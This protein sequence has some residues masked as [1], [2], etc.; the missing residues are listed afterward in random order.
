M[1]I[2]TTKRQR[3]EFIETR[4]REM[5]ESGKYSDFMEIEFELCRQGFP[6]ARGLLDNPTIRLHLNKL[7]QH[8]RR[9]KPNASSCFKSTRLS[10]RRACWFLCLAAVGS[11]SSFAKVNQCKMARAALGW[12]T[13]KLA[14]VP[15]VG[16]NTVNQFEGGMN[17]RENNIGKIRV[18]LEKAG[19]EFDTD[20]QVVRLRP[21]KPKGKR[22]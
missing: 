15:D 18:A 17:S 13:R 3:A 4:S 10:A 22:K 21:P 8:A 7:C 1:R 12:S 20:G 19:I 14:E 11:S 2:M 16:L 9:S 6:E 5:A